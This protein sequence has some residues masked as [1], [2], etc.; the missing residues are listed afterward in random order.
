MQNYA[1]DDGDNYADDDDDDINY[2][3]IDFLVF[4]LMKQFAVDH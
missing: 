1:D 4:V 2:I 3:N